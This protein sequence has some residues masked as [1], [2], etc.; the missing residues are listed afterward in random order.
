MDRCAFRNAISVP[1][2]FAVR[3]GLSK[4]SMV[5]IYLLGRGDRGEPRAGRGV[6]RIRR[7][8]MAEATFWAAF[9]ER[10]G[11]SALIIGAEVAFA[12]R[13]SG[14]NGLVMAPVWAHRFPRF[15]LS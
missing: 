10:S 14:G 6:E 5:R 9:W 7:R 11:A 13:L 4:G 15:L 3:G 2:S 8:R 12:F 1:R